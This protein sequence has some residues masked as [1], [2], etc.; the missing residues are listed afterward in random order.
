MGSHVCGRA[1]RTLDAPSL[2]RLRALE[3]GTVPAYLPVENTERHR[4]VMAR[5]AIARLSGAERVPYVPGAT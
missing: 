3:A 2:L 1:I 4:Q 5:H